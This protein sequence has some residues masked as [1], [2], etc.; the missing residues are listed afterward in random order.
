M[1]RR[2]ASKNANSKTRQPGLASP[3][4]MTYYAA[5]HI[6]AWFNGPLFFKNTKACV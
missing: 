1:D 3:T 6:R 4:T 5:S 2:A